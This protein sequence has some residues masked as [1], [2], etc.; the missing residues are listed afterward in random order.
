MLVSRGGGRN[1]FATMMNIQSHP[2][3]SIGILQGGEL[4]A[5]LELGGDASLSSQRMELHHTQ[6]VKHQD[7]VARKYDAL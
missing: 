6:V 3:D 5:S 2:Y 4:S 1:T 7:K